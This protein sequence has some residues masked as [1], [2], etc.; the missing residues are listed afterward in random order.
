[1][2]GF[3]FV[4]EGDVGAVALAVAGVTVSEEHDGDEMGEKNLDVGI[5]QKFRDFFGDGEGGGFGSSSDELGVAEG[6]EWVVVSADDVL[7][8][9]LGAVFF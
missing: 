7:N 2:E 6:P 3:G 8:G 9:V 5:L 1:M 4:G